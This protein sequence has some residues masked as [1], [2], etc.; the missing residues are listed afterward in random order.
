MT[1]GA[2]KIPTSLNGLLNLVQHFGK[3]GVWR[4][5][6]EMADHV[7]VVEGVMEMF[8]AADFYSEIQSQQTIWHTLKIIY[9]TDQNICF[10]EY[11]VASF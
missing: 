5:V 4:I 3:W 6:H 1:E 11:I 10:K 8:L 9:V 7:H 2:K